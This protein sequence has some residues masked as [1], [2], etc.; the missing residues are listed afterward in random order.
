MRSDS[1]SAPVDILDI[2]LTAPAEEVDA[3]QIALDRLIR[4]AVGPRPP[5]R[6]AVEPAAPTVR[7]PIPV[8]EA[9]RPAKPRKRRK[10][11]TTQYLGV[12]VHA[13]LSRVRDALAAGTRSGQ[14]RRLGRMSKSR[15][16]ETALRQV[17]GEFETKGQDSRLYRALV[18]P[19]NGGQAPEAS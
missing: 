5:A 12:D 2:L 16:V 14:G 19:E 15:I 1:Q 18:L 8:R 17:L 9:P 10:I 13:R 6:Q 3:D 4:R 7:A 11:K